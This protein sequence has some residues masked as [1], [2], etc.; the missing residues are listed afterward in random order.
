MFLRDARG[1]ESAWLLGGC[2]S[3]AAW[4]LWAVAIRLYLPIEIT[5]HEDSANSLPPLQSFQLVWQRLSSPICG[6]NVE[7][8]SLE[9]K[10]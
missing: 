1:P 3:K 2:R 7:Q 8:G 10:E 5:G 6:E 9:A 4:A